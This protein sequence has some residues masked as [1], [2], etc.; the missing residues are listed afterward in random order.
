MNGQK[1]I[2]KIM[3]KSNYDKSPSTTV[4]GTLWKGW[5][6]VLD[7]LKEVCN[8]PEKLARKVVVIECYHGVYTDKLA[9]HLVALEPSLMIHSDQCFKGVKDIEKMTYPYLTDDRLLDVAHRFTMRTSW[10]QTK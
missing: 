6:S 1:K 10:M 8:V 5:E 4:D 3:R 9:E 7:K 2:N